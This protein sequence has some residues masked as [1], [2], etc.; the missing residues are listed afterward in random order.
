MGTCKKLARTMMAPFVG[1]IVMQSHQEPTLR[2]RFLF[3]RLLADRFAG[4]PGSDEARLHLSHGEAT[5]ELT[6]AVEP[7]SVRRPVGHYHP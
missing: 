1:L 7:H 5:I 2:M 4:A 3:T 6:D